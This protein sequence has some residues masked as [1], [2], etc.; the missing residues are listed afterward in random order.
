MSKIFKNFYLGT[1]LTIVSK[2]V[3][4]PVGIFVAKLVGAEGY[5]F[6]GIVAVA[7][8]FMSYGNLGIFNGLNRELPISK[9]LNSKKEE[10]SIYDAVYS[11]TL[12]STI[13]TSIL[14]IALVSFFDDMS[15]LN[16]P[17]II[18]FIILIYICGN[19]ES[20]FYNSVKGE[21]Q[22][23]TWSIYVSIRPVLDSLTALIFVYFLGYKGFILS[24]IASKILSTLILLNYYSG[25]TP[26]FNISIKIYKLLV[27]GIP[28]MAANLS[29]NFLVKGPIL[30]T[31]AFLPIKE[32]GLIAFGI[33]NLSFEEKIPAAHIFALAH[34]NEFAKRKKDSSKL[35]PHINYYIRSNNLIFHILVN[36]VLG[37]LLTILYFILINIFLTDFILLNKF[38][39]EITTF[40]L[41]MSFS[42]FL[43]QLLDIMKYLYSKII[44]IFM[45]I[46]SFGS[47]IF[48]NINELNLQ[49]ILQS[50]MFSSFIVFIFVYIFLFFHSRLFIVL[51]SF[52]KVTLLILI[53][54]ISLKCSLIFASS[55]DSSTP[56]ASFEFISSLLSSIFTFVVTYG[57][58]FILIFFRQLRSSINLKSLYN[59]FKK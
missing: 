5:G 28:I 41:I 53:F 52:I 33:A 25:S 17:Q 10:E 49:I 54:Y 8:Q 46:L 38:L 24:I 14:F 22:L 47:L 2:L 48:L 23:K 12:I 20:F 11:F 34:R 26:A 19:I 42:F 32:I 50:Y 39:V 36:G 58:A 51:K 29:K 6:Y 35:K 59:M 56:L 7:A 27:T 37:G 16:D 40:F 30:I 1:K 45:G 44:I 18:T 31:S 13:T 3:T 15:E 57:L 43:M 9:A 21:N 4:L 55:I